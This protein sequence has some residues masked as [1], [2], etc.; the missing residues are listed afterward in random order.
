[1]TDGGEGTTGHKSG[2]RHSE[3]TKRKISE[4]KKGKKRGPFSEEHRK[5]LS[6]AAKKRM[7]L[8]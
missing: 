5:R 6:S 8:A 1:M 7:R 3:A 4:A 2:H